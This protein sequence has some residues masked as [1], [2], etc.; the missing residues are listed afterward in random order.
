MSPRARAGADRGGEHPAGAGTGE[1]DSSGGR[2]GQH[3]RRGRGARRRRGHNAPGR[4]GRAGRGGGVAY[5]ATST[6]NGARR[7]S[8]AGGAT[9]RGRRRQ[10]VLS[11][12]CGDPREA[13]VLSLRCEGEERDGSEK[14]PPG[15]TRSAGLFSAHTASEAF[16]NAGR[17]V[18]HPRRRRWPS[19]QPAPTGVS[20][21]SADLRVDELYRR[22]R[23]RGSRASRGPP[24]FVTAHG[25]DLVTSGAAGPPHLRVGARERR[26]HTGPPAVPS[27]PTLAPPRRRDTLRACD[28]S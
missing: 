10:R 17:K 18:D 11:C 2:R 14:A 15:A 12:E 4:A 25:R 7:A 20:R 27:S 24:L 28:R 9:Q 8:G 13:S 19:F 21:V 16:V 1:G 26:E 23:V 6:T 3:E 5:G 22:A